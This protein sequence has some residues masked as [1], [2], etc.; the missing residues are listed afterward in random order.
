M[1]AICYSRYGALELLHL[2]ERPTPQPGW[3][4]V[5][6]RVRAVALNPIDVVVRKGKVRGLSGR[7]FPR[8]AGSD[9]AGDIVALGARAGGWQVG[10]RVMGFVS[11]LRG[12][13]FAEFVRISVHQIGHIP[14]GMSYL[15]AAALPLAGQTV[16]RAFR[17]R[18]GPSLRVAIH[19]AA[20]GVGTLAV[21]FAAWQ[22][23]QVVATCS[24][25]NATLVQALGAS[26][27]MDYADPNCFAVAAPFDFFFDVYGNKPFSVVGRYL[28][29][30]GRHATTIP[31]PA[32]FLQAL[33]SRWR[34]RVVV[35]RSR[36]ADLVQL[37]QGYEQG[38][39]RPVI[40]RVYPWAEVQ[41]ATRYLETKR[42]QG[43]IVLDLGPRAGNPDH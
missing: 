17:H 31:K 21:Q 32:N 26:Q 9:F 10:D 7:A 8:I 22:G 39:L 6:V 23:A 40:D 35:V 5:L 27:V 2:A 15:E 37:A 30:Q 36:Q 29:P 11:P 20:G 3:G 24:P 38:Q 33:T 34:S 25:R 28:T 4:E 13:G 19:G 42:A 1:Q 43:K 16:I 18:L 14:T 41:A 12:G